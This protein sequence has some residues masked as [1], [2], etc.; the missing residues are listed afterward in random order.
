MRNLVL[1]SVFYQ[2]NMGYNPVH[3]F[4]GHRQTLSKSSNVVGLRS[5]HKR[6]MFSSVKKP[7][8]PKTRC[9]LELVQYLR[10]R[11]RLRRN[12]AQNKGNGYQRR[13]CSQQT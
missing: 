6:S 1:P 13:T 7:I 9:H 11:V 4:L 10:Q 5:L 8:Q 2:L 3:H 12:F